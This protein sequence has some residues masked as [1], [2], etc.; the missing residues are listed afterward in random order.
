LELTAGQVASFQVVKLNNLKP[1]Q[2]QEFEVGS[3][4][5]VI[6]ASAAVAGC[7]CSYLHLDKVVGHLSENGTLAV[8]MN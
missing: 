7:S 3:Q 5:A 6:Y 8:D 2:S 4:V 1:L